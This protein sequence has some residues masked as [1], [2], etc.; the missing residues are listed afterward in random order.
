MSLRRVI[1]VCGLM[2]AIFAGLSWSAVQT[3]NST[4]DEPGHSLSGW[5]MWRYSDFRLAPENPSFWQLWA[6]LPN[7]RQDLVVGFN[8]EVFS[9]R[10]FN[11]QE[12]IN[13]VCRI[14]YKTPGNDGEAF[15]RRSRAMMLIV[16][17]VLGVLIGCWSYQLAGPVA[18]LISVGVF[19]FDPNF[20][21]HSAVVKSDVTLA[22]AMLGL[23][24]ATWH[25]GRRASFARVMVVSLLCGVGMN[26][27]FSGLILLLMLGVM[28]LVRVAIGGRWHSSWKTI[29]TRRGCTLL[30]SAV[31]LSA[32]VV[33]FAM[34][35]ACYGLR[36]RPAVPI[37]ARMDMQAIRAK[38]IIC[39]AGAATNPPHI[40][41]SSEIADWNPSLIVKTVDF[42]NS[43]QLLPQAMLGG[44][45]YQ[46]ACMQVWPS[47]LL[48]RLYGIGR[49]YYFP[50]AMLFKTPIAT[51]AAL[52]LT[53]LVIAANLKRGVQR[54]PYSGSRIWSA[55]CLLVP[56]CMFGTAAMQSNLDIGLR[57]VLPVYP[58][59]FVGVGV[60]FSGLIKRRRRLGTLLAIV[61]GVMLLGETVSAWPNYISFF[62]AAV[63]GSR[64]GFALLGDSNLDWGQDLK[65]LGEW[66]R[67]NPGVPVYV[68]YFGVPD[69][70]FFNPALHHFEL[71]EDGRH[72]V[73]DVPLQG[74]G[75]LAV[76]AN[77]LQGL[78]DKPTDAEF[79]RRL[80]QKQPDQIVGGSIY[81]YRYPLR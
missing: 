72:V 69:V 75:M 31:C 81:L 68:H 37:N 8:S 55:T 43:H 45:L 60:I 2:L 70:A 63:G 7:C 79:F 18:A 34:T 32:V 12:G 27:K 59:L 28:L 73:A 16:G 23:G 39:E 77:Y 44:L 1:A 17:I 49:W 76:S 52:L 21:A 54:R 9:D 20:L 15:V 36:F 4:V 74:E 33:C 46:H 6:A 80:G 24:Y 11:S 64:G 66:Q 19:S 78:Y 53:V 22:L 67:A 30:T 38:A 58:F 29:K 57:S 51:L 50:L 41:T 65:A 56:L 47:Y 48:G 13:W 3:K 10:S 62:N 5:L 40:P 42:A 25:L 35:W 26:A 14:L 61:L 71:A